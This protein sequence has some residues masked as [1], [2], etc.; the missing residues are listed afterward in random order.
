MPD[1]P[2]AEE[3]ADVDGIQTEIE[4]L[5]ASLGDAPTNQKA[6]I[7]AQIEHQKALLEKAKV[8]LAKCEAVGP[9]LKSS[10]HASYRIDARVQGRQR[11]FQG[12]TDFEFTFD[13]TRLLFVV[14][15][16]PPI[17]GSLGGG[18][19][20]VLSFSAPQAGQ[21]TLGDFPDMRVPFDLTATFS[22]PLAFPDRSARVWLDTQGTATWNDGSN[23][24]GS[25]MNGIGWMKMVGTVDD[26]A[27]DFRVAMEFHGTLAPVWEP[28]G[29]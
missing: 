17:S 29:P 11:T 26:A 3:R 8:K 25:G 23:E 16:A 27:N 13:G 12:S 4:D 14:T 18:F 20:V 2:C 28:A 5:Q 7:V 6:H 9:S 1:D 21:V 24:S 22:G 10:W 15:S 19:S